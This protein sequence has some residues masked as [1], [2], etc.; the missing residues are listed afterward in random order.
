VGRPV[1]ISLTSGTVMQSM[2]IPQLAGQIYAMPG[3]TSQLNLAASRPGVYR[4]ENTQFNGEGFQNETFD[5][6]ALPEPAYERWLAQVGAS[7]P[8][9]DAAA[10]GELFARSSPP[11]PLLYSSPPPGLFQHI[12]SQVQA[13]SR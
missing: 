3:M 11:R 13:P 8:P 2:L 4:G 6:V 1:H 5:V 10:Y 9:L 12:I 7:A